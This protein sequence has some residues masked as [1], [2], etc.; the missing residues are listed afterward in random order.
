MWN[1]FSNVSQEYGYSSFGNNKFDCRNYSA[2]EDFNLGSSC[3]DYNRLINGAQHHVKS[4]WVNSISQQDKSLESK[5]K[6]TAMLSHTGRL[7][8]DLSIFDYRGKSSTYSIGNNNIKLILHNVSGSD[9]WI[10][11]FHKNL[12]WSERMDLINKRLSIQSAGNRDGELFST[13]FTGK[14]KKAAPGGRDMMSRLK[15]QSKSKV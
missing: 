6:P 9:M 5:A 12:S 3:T 8:V 7:N 14:T 13:A 15:S 4:D 1:L 11:K 10:P 2:I